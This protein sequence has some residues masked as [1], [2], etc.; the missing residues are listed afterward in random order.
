MPVTV[1]YPGESDLTWD[2][3]LYAT[4]SIGDTIFYDWNGN[5]T[6]DAGESGLPGVTVSLYDSSNTSIASVNTDANGIYLFDNLAADT[7]TVKVENGVPSGYALTSDPDATMDEQHTVILAAN[8][9]YLDADFGY[10]PS[11]NG[12]IGD[13]VFEDRDGD[14]VFN[15]L[16][17]GIDGV[18]LELYFDVDG[19]GVLDEI[20]LLI[21]TTETSGGG[22]YLFENLEP[23]L[24]YLIRVQD[25]SA[26]GVDDY[27]ATVYTLT[28]LS[29]VLSV[30]PATFIAQSDTVTTADF[31]YIAP[32][33]AAISGY[34]FEDFDNDGLLNNDDIPLPD[35]TVFLYRLDDFGNRI[36]VDQSETAGDGYYEFINLMPGNYVVVVASGDPD[37]PAGLATAVPENFV[38]FASGEVV[39]NLDFP[40]VPLLSKAV[41]KS[42]AQP[43]E[44]LTYTLSVNPPAAGPLADVTLSDPLPPGTTF[45]SASHGG[46]FTNGHVTWE[47]GTVVSGSQ[48]TLTTR[49]KLY[50]FRGGDTQSFWEYDQNTATWSTLADFGSAV[51]G[52]GALVF[53]GTDIF[54]LAGQSSPTF[55]RFNIYTSP[56][57]IWNDRTALGSA[58]EVDEGGSLTHLNGS[59]YAL[60]GNNTLSFQRYDIATDTWAA[61]AD[62]PAT[63]GRGGCLANDGTYVYALR[64]NNS[65][66][67]WRYDPSADEWQT[68]ASAPAHIGMAGSS[69]I[70]GGAAMAHDRGNL[71]VLQGDG[72][73]AFWRYH[74]ATDTW[75]V[76]TV[77][78]A[79]MSQPPYPVSQGGA[80]VLRS[81]RFYVFFGNGTAFGRYNIAENTWTMLPN[82]PATVMSGGALVTVGSVA[83]RETEMIATPYAVRTDDIVTVKVSMSACG[84]CPSDT[85]LQPPALTVTATGG[86]GATLIDGPLPVP[87][88]IPTATT[89]YYYYRYSVTA[90]TSDAPQSLTF[91]IPS[92]FTTGD[93]PSV[94]PSASANSVIVVPDFMLTVAVDD[95]FVDGTVTNAAQFFGAVPSAGGACYVLSDSTVCGDEESRLLRIDSS[96]VSDIGPVGTV[97][98]GTLAWAPDL[99]RLYL[100][101]GNLFGYL[102]I[103]TGAF[104]AIGPIVLST[105]SSDDQALEGVSGDLTAG[106]VQVTALAFAS[107]GTLFAILRRS[108]APDLLFQINPLTGRHVEDAFGSALD[109]RVILATSSREDIEGLAFHPSGTLFAVAANT[110][111][112]GDGDLLVTIPDPAAYASNV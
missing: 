28:T 16:D 22:A 72:Q 38:Q 49:P 99:S 57:Y 91:S 44:I 105:G 50:A 11:G 9:I 61:A 4:G 23:N 27:F 14:G 39:E 17:S 62:T 78:G 82:A 110:G 93:I 92:S 26:S 51:G 107:D 6:Q 98:A 48:G 95:S 52:G 89:R 32:D 94:Y 30:L 66:A 83:T 18:M 25:G 101:D 97:N 85:N 46:T 104:T 81:V 103:N 59:I 47:L 102:D 13:T 71:Y 34:V 54:G 21:A 65:D 19:N 35:V 96:G 112:S 45:V 41:D 2:A 43:D 86:A 88:N 1:L 69:P 29:T 90:G 8:Q 68:L 37:L 15:N 58:A 70:L 10:Q 5:G 87:Q 64:G 67:L 77:S 106:A 33:P 20:D 84:F 24:S 63:V 53:T 75:S 108:G 74:I 55:R 36:L 79:P 111:T 60:V 109:Y 12:S 76:T 42:I 7:Y 73:T 56:D 40:F 31:G 100:T 80:M 3:G